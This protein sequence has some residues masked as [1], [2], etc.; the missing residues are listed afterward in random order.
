MNN[1]N[2]E[3]ESIVLLF[4]RTHQTQYPIRVNHFTKVETGKVR[5]K[6]ILGWDNSREGVV[7]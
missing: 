4:N 6:R 1:W 5:K 7:P 3:S 2:N